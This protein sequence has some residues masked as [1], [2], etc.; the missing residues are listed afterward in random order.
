MLRFK[1]NRAC[2]SL[3]W[4]Y[5]GCDGIANHQPHHC[6]LNSLF[7]RRSKKTSK[8]RVTGL[9]AGNSPGTGEFPA[10]MPSNAENVSIWWRHHEKGAPNYFTK[11]PSSRHLSSPA[12]RLFAQ[13]FVEADIKRNIKASYNWPLCS[14]P[15]VTDRFPTQNA[16]NAKIVYISWH[17]HLLRLLK[18]HSWIKLSTPFPDLW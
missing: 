8:F 15:T 11:T 14:N 18:L 7:G 13:Q 16:S 1:V 17:H 9:C 12:S 3:R 4:R 5:N 2:S 6:L 10:Q